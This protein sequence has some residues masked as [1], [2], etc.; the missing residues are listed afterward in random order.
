VLE[1]RFLIFD[2]VKREYLESGAAVMRRCGLFQE[3]G[4]KSR[5]LSGGWRLKLFQREKSIF[6]R[7]LL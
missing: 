7:D 2:R 6:M 5:L 1:A 4:W 3:N